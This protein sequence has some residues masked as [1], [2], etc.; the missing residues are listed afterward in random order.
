MRAG[1][2]EAVGG[3]DEKESEYARP[4]RP[5][6]DPGVPTKAEYEGTC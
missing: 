1:G 2:V 4:V 3:H 6:R 5:T